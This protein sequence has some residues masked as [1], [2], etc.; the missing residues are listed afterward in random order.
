LETVEMKH[1]IESLRSPAAAVL[2]LGLLAGAPRALE[3]PPLHNTEVT[4]GGGVFA[5]SSFED[6]AYVSTEF[7]GEL[8]A[9]APRWEPAAQ[10]LRLRDPKGREWSFTLDNPFIAVQGVVYNLTYPVRRGPERIYL[11][12]HPL[13]RLLRL[14]YGIDLSPGSAATIPALAPSPLPS[15]VFPDKTAGA[16]SAPGQ[17][18]DMTLEEDPEGAEL[19]IQAAPGA[20]WQGVLA[21]PHYIVRVFGGNLGAETPRKLEGNGPIQS[22]EARQQGNT[23]QFTL[24]LRS[25]HDSVELAQTADGWR[26]SVRPPPA[27]GSAPPRG[28]IIVDAGPGGND[29]GAVMKGVRDTDIKHAVAKLLRRELGNR[30]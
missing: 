4:F 10:Q 19:R 3:F 1:L 20:Q 24:R 9:S 23:T 29:P 2:F 30:G 18:T 27:A 7:L 8:F 28:T 22:V 5:D 25:P 13:L 11:P 21:R 15:S 26:V 17:I 12:L 6:V 14:H 16:A